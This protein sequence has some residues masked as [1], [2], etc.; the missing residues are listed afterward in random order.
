MSNQLTEAELAALMPSEL[1]AYQTPIPTQIVS[2]DEFYPDPQNERQR[3]VDARLL[4]MADELGG[5][6]GLNRRRF[7]QSAAGMAASFVAMNEVYGPLFDVT[8]AE[9]ATPAMAQERAN[10]LKDQFIMDMHTHFLRDDTR[11]TT[12]LDM[13]KAVG[14]AGWNKEL[15]DHEQTIDDLK[16]NNYKKE[17]FLDSDTKISLISSSPSDIEQDWF[18][19]NEQMADARRKINDEAGSRRVFAHMLFTPGQPG[20]LDTLAAGPALTPEACK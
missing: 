5:K 1:C 13:R 15:S 14:K 11:I 12:F 7:F 6:Q 9:A 17:M 20:W 19:T 8:K 18:L 16:F 4:A 3:E 2:S 10:A